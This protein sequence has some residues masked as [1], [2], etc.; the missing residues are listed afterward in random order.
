MKVYLQVLK[1][2]F[3]SLRDGHKSVSSPVIRSSLNIL[4]PTLYTTLRM[5]RIKKLLVG[6]KDMFYPRRKAWSITR[7]GIH[8]LRIK[9]VISEE[10]MK[11]GFKLI[12]ETSFW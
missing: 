7:E 4:S 5:L 3:D 1:F 12:E 2:V 10:E 9:G 6:S 11:E 8:Y